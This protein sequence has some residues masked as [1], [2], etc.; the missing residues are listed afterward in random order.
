[1]TVDICDEH[2]QKYKADND[3]MVRIIAIDETWIKSYDPSDPRSSRQCQ[4]PGQPP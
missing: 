2:L 4:L 1:L 3:I